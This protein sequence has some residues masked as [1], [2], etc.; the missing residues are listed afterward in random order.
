MALEQTYSAALA[1]RMPSIRD[2]SLDM[3]KERWLDVDGIRTRYFDKGAGEPVVF[4][5]GGNIGAGGAATIWELNVPALSRQFNAIAVDRLGQGYTD[6]PKCDDDYSM[7]ASVQHSAAFLRKLG[8]GPYHLVGHSRGG[9]VVARIALE[10]PELVK[11]CTI[12]SSGS[13]SP[14]FTENG[15]YLG[16]PPLPKRTRE[17]VRWIYERYSYNIK[18]VTEDWLD[19]AIAINTT[20]RDKKAVHKMFEEG[21]DK[22]LFM[23]DLNRQRAETHRWILQ[24]GI[25]CPTLVVWGYNDR[26]AI[27]ENGKQL[28]EML[29][30]KQP[31]TEV[32]IFNRSGHFVYR[33][34]PEAFNGMLLDYV[35][36]H[37]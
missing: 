24:R 12:I 15:A 35:A 22:K 18:I 10:Y 30:R 17:S 5:H 11:T 36:Q 37:S 31:K 9:Y 27:F 14:G 32:R 33:E 13:L 3:G 20:E 21:L 6:N 26:T 16:K 34:H 23:P 8:K 28:I 7:H 29:M 25:P 19:K 2:N 1:D 4:F